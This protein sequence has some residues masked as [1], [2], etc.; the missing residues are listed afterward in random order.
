MGLHMGK[1]PLSRPLRFLYSPPD[2]PTLV[3][4]PGNHGPG[5]S[6]SGRGALRAG[7]KAAGAEMAPSGAPQEAQFRPRKGVDPLLVPSS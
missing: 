1:P 3:S 4:L 2:L 7:R 6:S 5:E